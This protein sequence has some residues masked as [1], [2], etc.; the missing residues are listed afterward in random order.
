MTGAELAA[1]AAQCAQ[2]GM[3]YWMGTCCYPCTEALYRSK[4]AQ[5]PSHYGSARTAQ[6]RRDI[7]AGASC[8]DCAGLI[9]GAAWTE[10]GA[11]AAR[12]KSGGCP[13]L[14]ADGLYRWC[15]RK[16]MLSGGMG[17]LPETPGLL[18]H[19]PGHVGVYIG[20]DEAVDARSFAAGVVKGPVSA[21][22]WTDWARLPFV[23]YA[24]ADS[25][26]Y[27]AM[28]LSRAEA[29]AL[30]DALNAFLAEGAP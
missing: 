2:S 3:R 10:L 27:G 12:Y 6:Y 11:H 22:G 13:D 25:F 26:V 19:K 7:A 20:G 9:K 17:A 24:A 18:L 30:R 28:R 21:A 29:A 8:A 5:Y 1:F 23:D 15:I 16:G 4:K 14:G